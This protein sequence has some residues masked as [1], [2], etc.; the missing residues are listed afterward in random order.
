MGIPAKLSRE[1]G[2]SGE[3][4]Y[5]FRGLNNII[6]MIARDDIEDCVK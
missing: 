2:I 3:W 5:T 1:T 6:Q 4:S